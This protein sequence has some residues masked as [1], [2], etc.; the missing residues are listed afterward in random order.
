V[1]ICMLRL[2][3]DRSEKLSNN[4]VLT[5]LFTESIDRWLHSM[6]EDDFG[7]QG[8]KKIIEA[9]VYSNSLGIFC[10]N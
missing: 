2:P 9:V 6:V 7:G 10:G 3:H 4:G 8:S 1:G 5:D